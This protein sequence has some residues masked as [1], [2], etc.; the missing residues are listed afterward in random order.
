VHLILA[1]FSLP[2]DVD[3]RGDL[4]ISDGARHRS[5]C[6]ARRRLLRSLVTIY[7]LASRIFREGTRDFASRFAIY[8]SISF[9]APGPARA[10]SPASTA[11]LVGGSL[12]RRIIVAFA[13]IALGR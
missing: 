5:E 8:P 2:A 13:I 6:A 11:G 9:H 10:G 7:I 4:L 1:M 12:I 3:A